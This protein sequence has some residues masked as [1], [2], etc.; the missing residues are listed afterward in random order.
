MFSC[1]ARPVRLRLREN[2]V[3]EMTQKNTASLDALLFDLRQSFRVEM[4][5]DPV[6]DEIIYL[7]FEDKELE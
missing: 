1:S 4:E 2:F 6:T 7:R 3:K 5:L